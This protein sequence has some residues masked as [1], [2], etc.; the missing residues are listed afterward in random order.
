MKVLSILFWIWAFIILSGIVLTFWVYI[1]VFTCQ[2][3]DNYC[4][5]RPDR[6][7]ENYTGDNEFK[8]YTNGGGICS[9]PFRKYPY[10]YKYVEKEE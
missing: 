3:E 1:E 6:C 7:A 8:T 10:H 4:Y 9:D 5:V 2:T